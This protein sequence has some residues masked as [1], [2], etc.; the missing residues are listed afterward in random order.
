MF[1]NPL[2]D[3]TLELTDEEVTTA[4]ASFNIPKSFTPATGEETKVYYLTLLPEEHLRMDAMGNG[5]AAYQLRLHKLGLHQAAKADARRQEFDGQRDAQAI[6]E[7]TPR[8]SPLPPSS[9]PNYAPTSSAPAGSYSIP[10]SPH[11][12]YDIQPDVA[13]EFLSYYH[14][15][16]AGPAPNDG[17]SSDDYGQMFSEGAIA[18]FDLDLLPTEVQHNSDLDAEGDADDTDFGLEYT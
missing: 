1:T 4:I 9:P 12:H 18:D 13:G 3:R 11:D 8:L 5:N 6:Q 16:P 17:G 15:F 7:Q 14:S 2:A 10:F